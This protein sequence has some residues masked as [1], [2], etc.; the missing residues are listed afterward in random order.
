MA[1]QF[2]NAQ[3]VDTVNE[4]VAENPDFNTY[5]DDNVG[6]QQ[7][8]KEGQNII[9]FCTSKSAAYKKLDKFMNQTIGGQWQPRR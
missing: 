8:K 4:F 7:W 5:Y 6:F 3:T 1:T 2:T 9:S